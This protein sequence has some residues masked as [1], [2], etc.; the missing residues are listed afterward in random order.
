LTTLVAWS[1]ALLAQRP[2]VQD[3]ALSDIAQ[4]YPTG[5]P[6]C[7]ADDDHKCEYIGALVKEL[8]RYYTVLRLSLPRASVKDIIFE[9]K[10]I[11]SG[12]IIFLNAWACNMDDSVWS[13]P[14]AFRPERW[15]EQPDAPL[16]TY[17]LGYRM[18]AGSL[19]ANR[20]LYLIFM[21]MLNS[22]KIDRA[23]DVDTHPVSG[24]VDQTQLVSVPKRYKVTFVPRDERA[25]RDALDGIKDKAS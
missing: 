25:L 4:Y 3:K 8:L 19:L 15:F 6:L 22:F 11:P 24:V 1:I 7:D 16:F 9:G 2:D 23:D 14:E 20:E 18:C 13:D 10:T 17:G 12:S 21:R 5:E